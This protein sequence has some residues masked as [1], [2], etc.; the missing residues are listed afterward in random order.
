[1]SACIIGRSHGLRIRGHSILP[2]AS[3]SARCSPNREMGD[4]NL[5]IT[6]GYLRYAVI[7]IHAAPIKRRICLIYLV[8]KC[9]P[10]HGQFGLERAKV[11]ARESWP[12]NVRET[13][14]LAPAQ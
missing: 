13:N 11:R 3:M 8:T 1:M 12:S 9:R 6:N 2:D 5:W 14:G 4:V 10:G 7:H